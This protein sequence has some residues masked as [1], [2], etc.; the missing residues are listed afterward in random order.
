MAKTAKPDTEPKTQDYK[1]TVR[2]PK[3]DFPMRANA[4]EQEPKIQQFW[5]ANSIYEEQAKDNPGEVFILHDGPP[6]AN[7]D[8]HIG[9]AMNKT[10]KDIINRYQSLRGR[11]VRYV[12]GWDCHGLPIELKVLQTLSQAE[13]AE[14]S[15]L[16]LRRKAREFALATIDAQRA[17]FKR[18]G[19]WGEWDTPYITLQPEYE[20]SQ[21]SVFGKM[22][23]KGYIYR[24][25]KPV[26]WSPSSRSALAE[27]ELEYP[28]TA[29]KQ[30]AHVSRSVYVKFPLVSIS[31]PHTATILAA[32]LL[33]DLPEFYDREEELIEALL[34]EREGI[35]E[36]S[37]AIWTTTPW[38]LPGNQGIC[39]NGNL[40]Y[41]LVS[42]PEFGLMFIAEALVEK[43]GSVLGTSFSAITTVKGEELE[44]S[45]CRHPLY[46]R[47]SEVVLGDHVTTDTGTGAVH[48]A[49]GHGAEDFDV[50]STYGL[51]V[52][53]PVNDSGEFTAEADLDR[54]VA[55]PVFAGNAVLGEGNSLV[56]EALTEAG[57]LLKEE[58]YRHKYPYDWRTKKPTIFRATTQWF[59]S[60]SAFREDVLKAIKQVHWVPASGENRIT[61]MVV[62]RSDWCISRQRVWGLP[63]PAFYCTN[64][65]NVLLTEAS[66]DAVQKAFLEHGSDIW[67]QKEAQDLLPEGISCAHCGGNTFRKE[68]DIM[69]VWF[70]SG[71]SWSGVLGRRG[72]LHYPADVYLEGSDQHRGWFQS[73]L[74]TCVATEGIAPYK[75]VITHGFVMDEKGQ[76]MSKSLGN[77]VDPRLV[78][79]GGK[80]TKKNPAYGADVLRLWVSS[81]DYSSDVPLGPNILAQ[82]GENYRKIRNTARYLLGS[83]ADFKPGQDL[84]PYDE[85]TE[86]DQYLLH[87]LNLV[88][89]EVTLAFDT[90][91]FSRF[92]QTIQNFC[93]QD[94]SNFY[95][96]VAKDRLYI[97]AENAVRRRSCQTVLY[98]VLEH[99]VRVIAPVLP[100]LAED[101]WQFLPYPSG[102]KSIFR[103]SWPVDNPQWF[104]PELLDRWKM[105]IALRD[106]VNI[107][108]ESARNDKKIGSALE[109]RLQL[110]ITDPVLGPEVERLAA[111]LRYLFIVSQVE[112]LSEALTEGTP[113]ILVLPALGK[114]CARCWNYSE[115][116]GAFS[117]H[118]ELCE[119]CVPVVTA[120]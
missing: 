86:I 67:W 9:H 47:M 12:P 14:L 98:H 13:R 38:T 116:V 117:E 25:L 55:T 50:A 114:K 99:L 61:G 44:G 43:L 41:A 92:F 53:S 96:D 52:T 1:H 104:Q 87:R 68:K 112:V 15:P 23:L 26:H 30:P 51:A 40:D 109:A 97:S 27:A 10:L 106:R 37:I 48:T 42:S 79:E 34:G 101:I 107:A 59:A 17:G 57:V 60:V 21:I 102:Q 70:D 56:I 93:V 3:T 11:R 73:S 31:Q 120:L 54:L 78:I 66:M 2:T 65:E 81:V 88:V 115:Q 28:E 84:V 62:D 4:A 77:V 45:L 108:L 35:P 20:A 82:M 63:I 33:P 110:W 36:M 74:L 100:H 69:D 29:D 119:R 19:V 103:A 80:D 46:K 85:L 39:L 76:K 111:E 5:E 18:Y 7:G 90:Y 16:D 105:L 64:C 95:F 22:A 49:P 32:S 58:A 94:L 8:L 91:Q 72:N 89:D 75:S 118:P 6:Y 83:L 24:G 71:S 113:E